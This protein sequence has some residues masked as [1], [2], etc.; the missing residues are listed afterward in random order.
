[1]ARFFKLSELS[2]KDVFAPWVMFP[3]IY[4][5][6][7][8]FG[9][10]PLTS[11]PSPSTKSAIVVIIGIIF[12]IF[13]VHVSL[14]VSNN[15]TDS[16]GHNHQ[17]DLYNTHKLIK[18][19]FVFSIISGVIAAII[20]IYLYGVPILDPSIRMVMSPK[21][22]ALIAVLLPISL[23][24]YLAYI[25]INNANTHNNMY[26]IVLIFLSGM[27]VVLFTAYRAPAIIFI[28]TFMGVLNFSFKKLKVI[29]IIPFVFLLGV[30]IVGVQQ[31][32][33]CK[34]YGSGSFDYI[35]PS[36]YPNTLIAAHLP[37]HHG[38]IVFSDVVNMSPISGL[39]HGD[40]LKMS[41]ATIAPGGQMCTGVFT[42]LLRET[43]LDSGTV[44]SIIGG[45]YLDFGVFGVA[46]FMFLIGLT[47][48][49]LYKSIQYSP[50]TSICKTVNVISYSYFLAVFIISIHVGLS[51]LTAIVLSLLFILFVQCLVNGWYKRKVV[52][53]GWI[54]MILIVTISFVSPNMSCNEFEAFTFCG[55][56]LNKNEQI[57]LD[58]YS[59]RTAI[60]FKDNRFK[61]VYPLGRDSLRNIIK[62]GMAPNI[63]YFFINKAP[64]P[65]N[66]HISSILPN[67]NVG[68][69]VIYDNTDIEIYACDIAM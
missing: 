52:L 68:I 19:F 43:S 26:Y 59:A 34:V 45:P 5:I 67:N 66:T 46:G 57:G 11:L 49:L 51:E 10:L 4:I 17:R 35:N 62:S 28:I 33:L 21:L 65:L 36:G 53:F 27:G 12:Y 7:F 16:S 18:C 8:I 37:S 9:S 23:N 24:F 25:L 56:T 50:E 61:V 38:A 29:Y 3:F 63:D 41:F 40:L 14:N 55:E 47:L 48:T 44:L 2:D 60:T 42:S 13:G 20:Q 15:K 22:F 30:L 6:Y 32:R 31:Y 64:N 58:K 1:M 54:I 69:D 39:F